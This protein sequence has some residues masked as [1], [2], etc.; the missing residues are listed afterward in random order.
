MEVALKW[1]TAYSIGCLFIQLLSPAPSSFLS[2]PLQFT[3]G[4]CS[5]P[6]G[7]T[8]RVSRPTCSEGLEDPDN[9]VSQLNYLFTLFNETLHLIYCFF[10]S[11]STL[12]TFT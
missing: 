6:L 3:N 10:F 9:P 4:R 2:S 5:S 11:P 12:E 1:V 8:K 7:M